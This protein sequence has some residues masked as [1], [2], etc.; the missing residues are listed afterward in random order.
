[1]EREIMFC[2]KC[3]KNIN[4]GDRFCSYCGEKSDTYVVAQQINRHEKK[5]KKI[6]IKLGLF[7]IVSII[8]IGFLVVL[9]GDGPDKRDIIE[10]LLKFTDMESDDSSYTFIYNDLI[11]DGKTKGCVLKYTTENEFIRFIEDTVVDCFTDI[12][13]P[14]CLE[15]SEFS[16]DLDENEIRIYFD[17]YIDEGHLSI[18]NYNIDKDKFTLMI[19]GKRYEA[20]DDFVKLIESYNLIQIMVND[21][22][23]F[24]ECLE[25]NGLYFDDIMDLKYY[26]IESYIEKNE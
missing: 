10:K 2:K 23:V 15:R 8:V 25:D 1:M 18:I 4:E 7:M 6:T 22:E 16:Y 5:S 17:V 21:I 9:S 26:Q 12:F 11:V 14:S 13:G 19:D 3:G 20:S 24:K